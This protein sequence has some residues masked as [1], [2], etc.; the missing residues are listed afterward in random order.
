MKFNIHTE[1]NSIDLST[2]ETELLQADPAAMV[3]RGS[4]ALLRVSTSLGATALLGLLNAAG[5]R[6]GPGQIETLPSECCG[7]CGG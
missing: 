2:V 6:I 1:A 7:G 4:P 3:D 5:A